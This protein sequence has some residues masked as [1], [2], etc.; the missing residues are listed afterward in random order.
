MKIDTKRI[1]Y[2]ILLITFIFCL[3][4]FSQENT[5]KK[6]KVTIG[7]GFSIVNFNGYLYDNLFEVYPSGNEFYIP[8]N[9]AGVIRV[10]PSFGIVYDINDFRNYYLT[11]DLGVYYLRERKTVNLLIGLRS[12]ITRAYQSNYF[13]TAVALAAEY[14]ISDHFAVNGE[15]QIKAMDSFQIYLTNAVLRVYL[16]F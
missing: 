16:Y 14:K 7:M 5:E 9:I 11:S 13:F 2:F 10:E 3:Q 15:Y 6:P 12:G 8:V 1:Q 4:G